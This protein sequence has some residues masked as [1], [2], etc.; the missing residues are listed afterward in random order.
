[1][2]ASGL[3]FSSSTHLSKISLTL[4]SQPGVAI[5]SSA[6]VASHSKR[7]LLIS[8]GSMAMLGQ[9]RSLEM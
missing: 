5:T 3:V 9:E 1:M 2:T 8:A 6:M 7:S 4:D